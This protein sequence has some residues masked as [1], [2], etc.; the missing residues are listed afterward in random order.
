MANRASVTWKIYPGSRWV[1]SPPPLSRCF[2]GG[3]GRT[4]SR[5]RGTS[6]SPR[7][8][9]QSGYRSTTRL[10]PARAALVTDSGVDLLSVLYSEGPICAELDLMHSVAELIRLSSGVYIDGHP[11]TLECLENSDDDSHYFV[12]IEGRR[13]D[14]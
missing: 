11:T 6:S 5:T 8:Q 14:E 2:A 10:D 3:P 7:D 1:T 4:S 9:N 13:L 12:R